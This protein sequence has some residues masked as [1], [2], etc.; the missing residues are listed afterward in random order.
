M[1]GNEYWLLLS[2]N[3]LVLKNIKKHV[4]NSTNSCM[5]NLGSYQYVNYWL[6]SAS[7]QI[8]LTK[9]L[10]LI[11]S[12]NYNRLN[13][14]NRELSS[15]F[16]KHE[17]AFT[18]G[19]K[20]GRTFPRHKN[21]SG[22]LVCFWNFHIIISTWSRVPSNVCKTLFLSSTVEMFDFIIMP[23]LEFL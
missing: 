8:I 18:Y 6:F 23:I 13:I 4:L 19:N 1:E 21:C 11:P 16:P 7:C 9:K 15:Y 3:C 17:N 5:T 22:M 2:W 12:N 14:M 20:V 10:T